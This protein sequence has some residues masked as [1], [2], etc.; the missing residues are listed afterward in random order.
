MTLK[1]IYNWFKHILFHKF[2]HNI[3]KFKYK[4]SWGNAAIY[5]LYTYNYL[6]SI[7]LCLLFNVPRNQSRNALN[8][9]SQLVNA[10]TDLYPY[11]I[12]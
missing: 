6:L 12:R 5:V 4:D 11:T 7:Y 2:T 10:C 3:Y 8:I 9:C 1:R